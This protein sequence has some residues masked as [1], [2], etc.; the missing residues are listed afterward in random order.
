MQSSVNGGNDQP[1]RHGRSDAGTG[2]GNVGVG[3]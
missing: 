3:V 2:L 1:V